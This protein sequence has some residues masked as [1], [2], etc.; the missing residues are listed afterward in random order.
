MKAIGIPNLVASRGLGIAI[1]VSNEPI[2]RFPAAIGIPT[3][4]PKAPVDFVSSFTPFPMYP[5]S[6]EVVGCV[7][8]SSLPMI[9]YTGLAVAHIGCSCPALVIS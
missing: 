4:T 8:G 2:N 6:Y 1:C 9:A 5:L 3:I 7:N